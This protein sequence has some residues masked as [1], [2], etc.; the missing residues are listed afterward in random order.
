MD[1]QV[2]VAFASKHG[3]TREIAARIDQ[4]LQ[5]AGVETD[6]ALLSR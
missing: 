5:E 3:A 2:L 4:V 1:K 6:P